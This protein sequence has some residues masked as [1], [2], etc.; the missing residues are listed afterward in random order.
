MYGN[1]LTTSLIFTL[2]LLSGPMSWSQP[3]WP[4]PWAKE[5]KVVWKD[6]EGQ[7]ALALETEPL[8]AEN[9]K[10]AIS[11]QNGFR[12]LEVSRSTLEGV[13]TYDGTTML[14][15]DAKTVALYLNPVG[16]N[17]DPIWATIELHHESDKARECTMDHLVPVI[18]F[19]IP[20]KHASS[21]YKMVRQR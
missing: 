17:G 14:P 4:F 18:T 16:N 10:I 13:V 21:N 5:C 15:D 6:M 11:T 1:W 8:H 20:N 19:E 12:L 7:Y 9:V 3:P 2:C